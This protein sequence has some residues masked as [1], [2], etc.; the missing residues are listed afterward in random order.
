MLRHLLWLYLGDSKPLGFT[1][2]KLGKKTFGQELQYLSLSWT[3]SL[4][5]IMILE[6]ILGSQVFKWSN[7]MMSCNDMIH[8]NLLVL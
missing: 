5:K 8:L 6:S 2:W 1:L 4:Q 3:T 7:D